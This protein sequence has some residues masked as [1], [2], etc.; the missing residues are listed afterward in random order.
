MS[1]NNSEKGGNAANLIIGIIRFIGMGSIIGIILFLFN[2]FLKQPNIKCVIKDNERIYS[3]KDDFR[4]ILIKLHP[5]MVI[6]FD[7]DTILLIYLEEYYEEENLK[8]DENKEAK[9]VQCHVEY[10]EELQKYIKK[11]IISDVCFINRKI[12]VAEMNEK[13]HIYVSTLGG[14]KYESEE[15]NEEKRYCITEQDGIV[16]DCDEHDKEITNRLYETSLLMKDDLESIETDEEINS[17][18]QGVTEEIICI[19]Q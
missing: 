10:V 19:T 15:G 4:S 18:I 12:S 9:A 13:L 1:K 11:K 5:Q 7:N 16:I 14:V 6:R 8:F 2:N 17:L 3:V